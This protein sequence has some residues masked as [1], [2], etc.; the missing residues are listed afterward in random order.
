[1]VGWGKL[2]AAMFDLVCTGD[3]PRVLDIHLPMTHLVSDTCSW[4]KTH[5]V[6]KLCCR[7]HLQGTFRPNLTLGQFQHCLL[8]VV[9]WAQGFPL[10]SCGPGRR[11]ILFSSS[12]QEVGIYSLNI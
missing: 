1:M 9:D 8:L 12:W 10:R 5:A 2:T 6:D 4:G 3:C 7:L 11:S